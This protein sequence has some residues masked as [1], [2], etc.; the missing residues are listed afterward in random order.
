VAGPLTAT[1]EVTGPF[2]IETKPYNIAAKVALAAADDIP[3]TPA[4]K[5]K[6][7]NWIILSALIGLSVA[8]AGFAIYK[9]TV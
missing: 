3:S 5:S 2:K 6:G 4:T 8:A 7:A 9:K 1:V